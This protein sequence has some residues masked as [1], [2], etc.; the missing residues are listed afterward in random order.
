[1]TAVHHDALVVD[2][3]PVADFVREHVAGSLFVD[4]DRRTFL[5]IVRLFVPAEAPVILVVNKGDNPAREADAVEFFALGFDPSITISAQHG[6]NTGDLADLIVEHLPPPNEAEAA[7]SVSAN[8]SSCRSPATASP[9][10]ASS[11]PPTGKPRSISNWP[12]RANWS[13][14]SCRSTSWAAGGESLCGRQRP[15]HTGRPVSG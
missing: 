13:R 12:R 3:R 11:A 8:A 6:R 1:M 2:V 15:H 7:A 14:P 10:T 4:F 5:P 9:P